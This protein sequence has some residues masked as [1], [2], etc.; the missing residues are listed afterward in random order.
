VWLEKDALAS[1]VMD[2]TNFWDVPL[3]VSRGQSSATLLYFTG[4]AARDAWEA[5]GVDTHVFV[6]PVVPEAVS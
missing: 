4:R 2:A 6:P 5:A 3:M 1:V